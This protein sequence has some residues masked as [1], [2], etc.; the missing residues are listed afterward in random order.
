MASKTQKTPLIRY[1]ARTYRITGTTR[2]LGT[3][4]A[5]PKIYEAFIAS[6]AP[7]DVD[8]GAEVDALPGMDAQKGTTVFLRDPD[9]GALCLE[10]YSI[11]G[12]LKEALAALKSQL[13][14]ASPASK[15]DNLVSVAPRFIPFTLDG[16]PI[17]EPDENG[18]V[19]RPIRANTQQGPR[20]ALGRSECIWN[21]WELTF[22]IKLCANEGTAK[23]KPLMFD[24]IE[25][26][27]EYGG[28][29]KGLG[30]WRNAQNG[31]FTWERVDNP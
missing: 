18:L 21:D 30:Q 24:A 27:L 6:R 9:T 3:K 19:E 1:E 23:S 29:F 25:A 2:I 7:A 4:P 5:D 8:T 11:K 28:E 22:T 15:V 16:E 10:A 26:A 31:M 14:I 12:F 17:M 20:T 13:A